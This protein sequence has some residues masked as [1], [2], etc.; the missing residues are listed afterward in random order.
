VATFADGRVYAESGDADPSNVNKSVK[1][2]WK[3]MALVRAKSRAL[4]DALGLDLCA[5]E[6][7]E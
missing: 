3:R 7:M 5:V 4:R 2:H 6:E 1:P